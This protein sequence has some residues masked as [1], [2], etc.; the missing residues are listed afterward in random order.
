MSKVTENGYSRRYILGKH[1]HM[2]I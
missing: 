2:A 1:E